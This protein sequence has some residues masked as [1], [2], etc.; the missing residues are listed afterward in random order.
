MAKVKAC[1]GCKKLR[2]TEKYYKNKRKRSDGT[3]FWELRSECKD[4][5]KTRIKKATKR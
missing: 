4:C 5:T 2:S 3:V 1:S